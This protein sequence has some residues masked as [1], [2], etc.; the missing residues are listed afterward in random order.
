MFSSK[1]ANFVFIFIITIGVGIGIGWYMRG[2]D[3]GAG[4]SGGLRESNLIGSSKYSFIDPLIGVMSSA[5]ISSPEYKNLKDV[6]SSFIEDKISKGDLQVSSVY[7][8]DIKRSDGFD[9]NTDEKYSPAS[10]TKVPTMITYFKIAEGDPSFLSRTLY[11]KGDKDLNKQENIVSPVQLAKGQTYSVDQLIEHMI[12]YSD[13]NAATMLIDY[14]NDTNHEDAFNGLYK[15]LGINEISATDDFINIQTYALFFRILYNSTYLN[16]D[17]SEKALKLMSESDFSKGLDAGVPNNITVS[18]KFGEFS[19]MDTSRKLL[20]RE[21]HNCGI[22]Y[23]P[24]NPYLLCVMTKGDD[25]QKLEN[26]I[27]GISSLVFK[28]FEDQHRI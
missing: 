17:M 18:Q 24:N 3:I 11:F 5:P 27:S 22:I 1:T 4:G 16:R 12:R 23:Y 9:I 7:F 8:R 25:F 14:L 28:S 13:N 21:L 26:A 20:K 6:I 10:L 15:D 2:G 19:M